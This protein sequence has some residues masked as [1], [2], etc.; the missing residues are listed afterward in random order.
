MQ[1]ENLN[2]GDLIHSRRPFVIPLYQRA[3]EW[4]KKNID[5][6]IEDINT[7]VSKRAQENS[8]QHF[9]G[10]IVS[11]D[12]F[13]PYIGNQFLVIDGQQRLA[14]FSMVL[15]LI[16]KELKE[17]ARTRDKQIK[18]FASAYADS[19]IADYL[20][21]QF[22]NSE[23]RQLHQ[24]RVVLSKVDR[25]FFESLLQNLQP[26]SPSR[27]S[28]KLLKGA[29]TNLRKGL[30]APYSKKELPPRIRI[31]NLLNLQKVIT[32]GCYMIHIVSTNRSEAYRLFMTLNDRGKS[33][34]EGDLLKSRTLE[35]LE[36]YPDIQESVET[37]WN[38]I[39]TENAKTIDAFLRAYF[40]SQTGKRAG[41]LTLY[42]DFCE[43]FFSF[44][45]SISQAA[46]QKINHEIDKMKHESITFNKVDKGDWPYEDPT[47]SMW[48]RDRLSRLSNS[49]ILKHTLCYP[50]LLSAKHCLSEDQ[51]AEIVQ[52]LE[53]FIFRYVIICKA[54]AGKLAETYYRHC[55]KIRQ[56]VE[57]YSVEDL[58]RDLRGLIEGDTSDLIFRSSLA[59]KLVYKSSVSPKILHFLSTLEDYRGWYDSGHRGTP[60]PNTTSV[61]DISSLQVE[62]IYPQ[63]AKAENTN[64]E[65][66][67]LKDDLGNLL[68]WGERDNK[69]ASNADFAEKKAMYAKSSVSLNRDLV[70][71]STWNQEELEKRRE[72]LVDMAVK[73]FT[74]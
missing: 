28:H 4:D 2:F 14:T 56:Q 59:E 60:E 71:F 26:P 25:P 3:Y 16:V 45:G 51:F 74:I 46:S 7:L 1:P 72:Q 23:G 69:V 63:N 15:A 33:L 34:S 5:N 22:V 52:I 66:E 54:H 64:K 67:P 12:D 8:D 68:F 47:T 31:Q 48:Y 11:V 36:E 13:S 18:E 17:I 61:F 50:L 24:S 37:H 41:R 6:F 19:I 29:W 40:P 65:L 49:K 35:L 70:D 42:A 73:V 62:H 53:L 44:D 39:L 20:E 58:R 43:A 57:N 32:D 38:A 9:F 27:D 30:I 10:G 21:Y 55:L